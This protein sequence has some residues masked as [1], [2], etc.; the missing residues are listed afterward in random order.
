MAVDLVSN[1]QRHFLA[2][3]MSARIY[4]VLPAEAHTPEVH[5]RVHE[6]VAEWLRRAASM[7]V[8]VNTD[9]SIT[10]ERDDG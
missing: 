8:R 9:N 2:N 4:D 7:A 6:V 5:A 10:V 3:T 1:H